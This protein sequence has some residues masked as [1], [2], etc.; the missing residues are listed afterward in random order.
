MT[1]VLVAVGM[2]AL[3]LWVVA[4]TEPSASMVIVVVMCALCWYA[5]IGETRNHTV[6][7]IDANQVSARVQPAPLT[8]RVTSRAAARHARSR[9]YNLRGT[10]FHCVI[11]DEDGQAIRLGFMAT[12]ADAIAVAE[13]VRSH[14]GGEHLRLGNTGETSAMPSSMLGSHVDQ[15][16]HPRPPPR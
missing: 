16:D 14:T 13:L 12:E 10:D 9:S 2:T 7:E 1:S 5:A 3:A 11:V 8:S 15:I 4:A 6:I